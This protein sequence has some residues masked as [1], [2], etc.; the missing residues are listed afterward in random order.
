[1]RARTA[2]INKDGNAQAHDD[3]EVGRG[4]VGQRPEQVAHQGPG[5]A[6][7]R[8][9]DDQDASG[10]RTV[11]QQREGEVA[12][13]PFPL[14]DQLDG[15][16]TDDGDDDRGEDRCGAQQEA[17]GDPGERD[18]AEAVPHQ[19][20]PAVDQEGLD[21]RCS[22]TDQYGRDE[23]TSHEVV[24]EDAHA[25]PNPVRCGCAPVCGWPCTWV[26]SA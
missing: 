2:T 17:Q 4:D 16:G 3:D 1:L 15:D 6:T 12:A 24:G 8:Q 10:D 21:D 19:G 9:V 20:Q 11:E 22:E 5:G 18:V 26:G 13:G 7:G 25:S 23:G 14:A